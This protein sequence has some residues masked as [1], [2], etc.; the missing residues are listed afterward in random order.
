MQKR[1]SQ[2]IPGGADNTPLNRKI[3]VNA[4]K[5]E[6]AN[7]TIETTGNILVGIDGALNDE[8]VAT[9][10]YS[11]SK[12]PANMW[13]FV[14]GSQF[15]INKHFM[16]RAEVGFLGSRTQFIGGLQYRFGL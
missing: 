3:P 16:V 7:R 9:V 2:W 10:Q 5:Y 15:Q 12:R 14:L 6:V 8:E 1:R 13:N 11:L 4:A